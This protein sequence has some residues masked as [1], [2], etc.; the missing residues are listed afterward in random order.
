M[1]KVWNKPMCNTLIAQEL[2]AHI[3]AAAWS[4]DVLCTDFVLR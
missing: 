4:E 1:K 3:K 2:S